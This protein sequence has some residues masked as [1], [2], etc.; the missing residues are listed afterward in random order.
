EKALS[1]L[2]QEAEVVLFEG[3]L[4]QESMDRVVHYGQQG[5]TTPSVYEAL[6]PEAVRAINKQLTAQAN[7]Q[8]LST[9][10]SYLDMIRP[11]T[12][13]FLELHTRGVRPWMAF[14]TIWSA[15][16]NWKHSMDVEAFHL[17]RKLGKKIEY[18][19]TLEDQ[20]EALDGIPFDRIVNYLNQFS[21]WKVHKELYLRAFLEGDLPK[22]F[23]MT[24][25]FPTRCES[26]LKKRDPIFF[27][28]MKTFFHK[29]RMVAFV[30]VAHIPG[31]RKMFLDEGYQATQEER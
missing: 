4:D 13:D 29:G 2:I 17:A 6:D 15:F 23:S 22:F 14:F 8:S 12:S 28:R 21:H 24:G 19:E 7:S 5:E 9:A 16:L 3:P 25:E 10:V 31:I 26:I 1:Q 11:T 18:L 20:L 30:G 27:E